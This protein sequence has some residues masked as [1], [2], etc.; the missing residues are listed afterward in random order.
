M[1]S[2]TVENYLK[3]ILLLDRKSASKEGNEWKLVF[4]QVFNKDRALA[5]QSTI[6][7]EVEALVGR[8]IKLIFEAQPSSPSSA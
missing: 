5:H 8:K 1:P 7:Q 2:E 6:E 3:A 4:N